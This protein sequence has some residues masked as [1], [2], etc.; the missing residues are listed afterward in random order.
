MILKFED[1]LNG[2]KFNVD[3]YGDIDISQN[4]G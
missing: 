2:T 1:V 3:Q 4:S